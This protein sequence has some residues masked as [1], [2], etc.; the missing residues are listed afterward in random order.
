MIFLDLHQS[1]ITSCGFS[2]KNDRIVT[3]SMDK[4]TKFFD[5][6]AKKIT[7]SLGYFFKKNVKEKFLNLNKIKKIS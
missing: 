6:V 7:I 1:S 5:I 2:P 3:T 4:S